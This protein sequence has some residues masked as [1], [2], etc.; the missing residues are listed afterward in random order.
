MQLIQSEGRRVS[1]LH[2]S[3]QIP[4]QRGFTIVETLVA[5]T[6]TLIVVA[7]LA[8][9][10]TSQVTAL[11]DQTDQIDLQSAGRSVVEI[12]SRDLRRAGLD[13]SCGGQFDGIASATSKT[14]RIKAD[15]DGSGLIDGADEDITYRYNPEARRIE[16]AAG[17]SWAGSG[18]STLV[19]NV[20]VDGSEIRYFDGE[21]NE[22]IPAPFLTK[23]QRDSIRRVR[24]ELSLRSPHPD[25]S[26]DTTL[27]TNLTADVTLRNRFFMGAASCS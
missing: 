8:R 16:R 23:E 17:S 24:L 11:R 19:D 10:E 22:L 12:A 27:G 18:F 4:A 7:S 5:M 14:V 21:G 6:V 1:R 13:P 15:L 3:P 25:T 20:D 9:F 26:A 2:P